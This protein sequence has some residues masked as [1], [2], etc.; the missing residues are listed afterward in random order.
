MTDK[1]K[2]GPEN[3][4]LREAMDKVM[5]RV[6]L[7]DI[8]KAAD[9]GVNALKQARLDPSASGY[10]KPPAGLHRALHQVCRER[11]KYFLDLAKRLKPPKE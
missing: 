10:R 2:A 3:D 5:A 1:R 6:T 4:E 7:E 11:A 9:C 8:A